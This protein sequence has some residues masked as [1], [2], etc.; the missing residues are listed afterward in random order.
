MPRRA[1]YDHTVA[2]R[3]SAIRERRREHGARRITIRLSKSAMERLARLHAT[4]YAETRQACIVHALLAF[5]ATRYGSQIVQVVGGTRVD[6]LLDRESD[7]RLGFVCKEVGFRRPSDA[8]CAAILDTLDP[9]LQPGACDVRATRLA[10]F[11]M[12]GEQVSRQADLA[13]LLKLYPERVSRILAG[14]SAIGAN[15]A[16]RVDLLLAMPASMRT[17]LPAETK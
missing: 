15:L 5:D 11:R 7:D 4:G 12:L 6:V 3:V 10:R 16:R 9:D 13:H 14:N 1:Q 17:T 2:T 8:F